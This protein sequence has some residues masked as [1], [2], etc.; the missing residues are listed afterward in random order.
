V[1]TCRTA[2]TVEKIK[3]RNVELLGFQGGVKRTQDDSL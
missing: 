3:V 1:S 2:T